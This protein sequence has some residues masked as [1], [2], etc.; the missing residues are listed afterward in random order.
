VSPASAVWARAKALA[1]VASA[2][3]YTD[4]SLRSATALSRSMTA[5]PPSAST[6]SW[7]AMCP[8]GS[9]RVAGLASA[10]SQRFM[11]SG[12]CR[13]RSCRPRRRSGWRSSPSTRSS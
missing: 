1:L 13:W 11:D 3:A 12:S 8:V 7:Y 6:S 4:A 9:T 5:L 2:A 10:Y